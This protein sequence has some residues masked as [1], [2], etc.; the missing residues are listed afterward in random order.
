MRMLTMADVIR[1][2]TRGSA[3][4]RWQT[5]HVAGLLQAAHPGL[6]T[7]MVVFATKGDRVLDTPLPLI[8]GKGLFTAELEAALRNGDIDYAVHSLKD[9]PTDEPGDLAIGAVPERANPLDVL[10]SRE[11]YTLD[12]LPDGVTVGT[13]S[14]RRAAQLLRLRPDLHIAGIRGNVDTRV[15]KALDPDGE[16]AAVVLARAGLERLGRL[17]AIGQELTPDQMLPAPGQGAL[18]VQGRDDAE[19]LERLA[20]I[21]HLDTQLAVTAERGFLSGLGGGCAVPI[22]AFATIENGQL[23]LRGRVIALDGSEMV[24][25]KTREPCEAPDRAWEIGIELAERALD[26]GAGRILENVESDEANR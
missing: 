17:D 26:Q 2:G 9:L 25:V 7:E 14:R 15:S 6:R 10:V 13:G 21:N 1:M 3:L 11:G 22:G 24:E 5:D 23:N 8:G 16:Y 4:A 19:S 12:T 18:G 20:A